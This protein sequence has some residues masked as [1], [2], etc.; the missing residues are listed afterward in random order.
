[1]FV[2]TNI[3][4][5]APTFNYKSTW[6][7]EDCEGDTYISENFANLM[8]DESNNAIYIYGEIDINISLIV[9][10]A[11]HKFWNNNKD[12][13]ININS[14]GGSFDATLSIIT[15]IRNTEN[16]VITNI[17]GVAFSAAAYIALAGNERNISD[18]YSMRR[19]C[20]G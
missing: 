14:P 19:E 16:K 2:K 3:P 20:E 15:A 7:T 10:N 6:V 17:T 5:K 8:V 9:T 1:M 4:F 13:T 18:S 12:I 11:I